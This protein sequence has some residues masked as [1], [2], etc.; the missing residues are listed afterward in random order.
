[1][2]KKA[3]LRSCAVCREKKEKRELLRVV[4][5]PTG[6]VEIDLTGKKSGRGAYICLNDTCIENAKKTKKL[7]NALKTEVPVE[8]YDQ[9]KQYVDSEK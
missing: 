4:R 7:D 5:R 8:I 2:P 9:V 3:V 1:M 6:E